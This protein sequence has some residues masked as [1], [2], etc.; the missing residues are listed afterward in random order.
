MLPHLGCLAKIEGGWHFNTQPNADV[1]SLGTG[2]CQG[3]EHGR[4]HLKCLLTPWKLTNPIYMKPSDPP[5]PSPCWNSGTWVWGG[6]D[7]WLSC[8]SSSFCLR[9][10]AVF[11]IFTGLNE[12]RKA[13]AHSQMGRQRSGEQVRRPRDEV[14][15]CHGLVASLCLDC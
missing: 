10:L 5:C 15:F 13:S 3:W 14:W 7:S 12:V 8:N 9:S 11:K 4:R 2:I 6:T 1:W